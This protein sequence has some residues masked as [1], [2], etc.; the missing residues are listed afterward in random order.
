MQRNMLSQPRLIAHTSV[1]AAYG[2]TMSTA[3]IKAHLG[4]IS[5]DEA[6]LEQQDTTRPGGRRRP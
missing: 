4:K 5:A 2:A 3:Q 6:H 1:S